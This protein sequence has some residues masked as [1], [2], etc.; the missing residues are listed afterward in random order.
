MEQHA[1]YQS[2]LCF[3]SWSSYQ[4]MEWS[5]SPLDVSLL[6]VLFACRIS[7]EHQSFSLVAQVVE[8]ASRSGTA[9]SPRTLKTVE[10]RRALS[11]AEPPHDSTS[12]W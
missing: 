6:V 12:S 4:R 5:Y 1:E 9:R 2:S 3:S 8:V 10:S 7:V 11:A